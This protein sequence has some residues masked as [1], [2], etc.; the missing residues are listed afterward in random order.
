MGWVTWEIFMKI[1][2]LNDRARK[3]K[4]DMGGKRNSKKSR[5]ARKVFFFFLIFP[6]IPLLL[7]V[8]ICLRYKQG[9]EVLSL[10]EEGFS[11]SFFPPF[12]EA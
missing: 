3:R 10:N 1:L 7:Q 9:G 2:A 12:L 8:Q 5:V 11:T 6:F 4:E